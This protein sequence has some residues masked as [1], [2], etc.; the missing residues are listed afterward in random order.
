MIFA[1]QCYAWARPMPSHGVCPSVCLSRLSILSKR[2]NISS[3]FLPSGS[4]SS[5]V[6]LYQTL[7]QYSDEDPLT[8]TSNAG[9]AGKNRDSWPIS[10][11]GIDT[12]WSV[13]NSFDYEVKCI[14]ADADHDCHASVNLVYDSKVRRRFCRA[15]LCISVCRPRSDFTMSTY[16]RF[17]YMPQTRGVWQ[18]PLVDV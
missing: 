5:L 4:H 10:G 6:C 11:S 18:R 16:S 9:G 1:A 3:I 2:V 13:I 14:T 7:W 15:M 17:S 12:W 8:G